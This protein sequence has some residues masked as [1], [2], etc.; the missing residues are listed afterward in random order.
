MKKNKKDKENFDNVVIK[1]V[2]L[3][4]TTIGKIDSN[5]G[6]LKGVLVLFGLLILIILVLPYVVN[7]VNNFKE[8]G[9]PPPVVIPETPT[10][11]E[12]PDDNPNPNDK[13]DTENKVEF[14]SVDSPIYKT[15][16]GYNYEIEV[17]LDLKTVD[18]N[19]TNA[20]GSAF[21]LVNSPMFI[22]LFNS[23]KTLLDRILITKREIASNTT[24]AFSYPFKDG[25]N[26]NQTPAYL[27]LETM[28]INDYPAITINSTDI[29]NVPFLTCS[30]DNTTL[31]YNFS[32]NDNNY[33]L[34]KIIERISVNKNDEDT[35]NTYETLLTS[36]NSIDGVKA[37]LNPKTNGFEFEAEINL[38][39]VKISEN[40][41]ILN[42][43][44]FYE[45]DTYAKTIAFELNSSGY[46]CR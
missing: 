27:T 41:R 32:E 46:K 14:I 42:S 25:T 34:D 35:V 33:L 40:K 8:G 24:I 12:I 10:T 28:S 21:L 45:K 44:A 7:L 31:I 19:V 36:Y 2:E 26:N 38:E 18:V 9:N 16:S 4:P 23:E 43:Y 20:S 13:S 29:N 15:I 37:E 3:T 39:D 6:G 17:N 1:N 22:E 11:P 5:E 30:K